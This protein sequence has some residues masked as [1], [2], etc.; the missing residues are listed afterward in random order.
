MIRSTGTCGFTR[1]GRAP[2]RATALRIAARS[3][4][5]GTPV[6]SCISTRPGMNAI[7]SAGAGH[8]ASAATSASAT[9]RLPARRRRSS[10]RILRVFGRLGTA[11]I[12]CSANQA[13]R[14]SPRR[15]QRGRRT[16]APPRAQRSMPSWAPSAGPATRRPAGSPSS[17]DVAS[18]LPKPEGRSLGPTS[19]GLAG[20]SATIGAWPTV[21]DGASAAFLICLA[22]CRVRNA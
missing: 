14:Y 18:I 5:A 15:P 8:A 6:K 9:S 22:A 4:T 12:P 19:H 3:T 2:A 7:A 13:N 1:A 10:S 16:S 11:L 17:A 21:A 20:T